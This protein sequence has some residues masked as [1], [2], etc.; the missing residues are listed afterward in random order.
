MK[1]KKVYLIISIPF[2][3]LPFM[4]PSV[5]QTWS[6]YMDQNKVNFL[7]KDFK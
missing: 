3:N 4:A 1:G 5:S 6:C 2:N 7:K